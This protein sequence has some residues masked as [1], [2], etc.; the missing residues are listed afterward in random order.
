MAICAA[1]RGIGNTRITMVVNIVANLV[2][3]VFN[4]FL[5]EG[6]WGFPRLGVAGAAIATA[7]GFTVGL[8]LTDQIL[9]VYVKVPLEKALKQNELR[10]GT[11]S[12]VPPEVI[13]N[14]W[15]N[16]TERVSLL[17][18]ASH[19]MFRSAANTAGAFSGSNT[20]EKTTPGL[21]E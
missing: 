16:L 5:I 1:Q 17:S 8:V 6:N 21:F 2:N 11:K 9:I 20:S 15:E 13:K 19:K 7:I 10:K 4:F 3:V 12:Y 18:T 14:M